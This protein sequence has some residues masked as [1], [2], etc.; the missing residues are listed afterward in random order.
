MFVYSFCTGISKVSAHSDTC[1]GADQYVFLFK[2]CQLL[3]LLSQDS[4]QQRAQQ[5]WEVF[6]I[7][8]FSYPWRK[9]SM[10]RL[11]SSMSSCSHW[12][13]ARDIFCSYY[14]NESR[15]FAPNRAAMSA[16]PTV[17]SQ[18]RKTVVPSAQMRSSTSRAFR[19][20]TIILSFA[21]TTTSA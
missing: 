16:K 18:K 3:S 4:L 1:R 19:P 20:E 10:L 12:Q 2:S 8:Q 15:A 5:L 21:A 6:F 17:K 13:P 9:V 14:R 11:F 7:R